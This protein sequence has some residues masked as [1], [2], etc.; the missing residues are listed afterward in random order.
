M[1]ALEH[2][3]TPRL[4]H[5][6]SDSTAKTRA[7]EPAVAVATGTADAEEVTMHQEA[8]ARMAAKDVQE[9]AIAL[10]PIVLKNTNT[11]VEAVLDKDLRDTVHMLVAWRW[12]RFRLFEA[13]AKVPMV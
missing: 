11:L 6:V 4:E 13:A 1:S 5:A 3:L 9:A 7:A 2:D 8:D 10:K 12:F